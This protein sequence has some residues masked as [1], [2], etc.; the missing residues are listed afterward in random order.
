[1]VGGAV[2][3]K[4]VRVVAET[5]TFGGMTKDGN[6]KG[7]DILDSGRIWAFAGKWP[8]DG[9][10]PGEGCRIHEAIHRARFLPEPNRILAVC[11]CSAA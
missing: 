7:T 11:V 6:R 8:A 9:T 5:A 4:L 10:R 3:N 1:M 2:P